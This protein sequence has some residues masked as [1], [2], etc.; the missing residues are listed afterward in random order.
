MLSAITTRRYGCSGRAPA[1]MCGIPTI[2]VGIFPRGDFPPGF[3]AEFAADFEESPIPF[4]LDLVDLREAADAL[5]DEV[6]RT[7]IRWRD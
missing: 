1:A 2:D 4:D 6:L 5:R 3:F 7:G